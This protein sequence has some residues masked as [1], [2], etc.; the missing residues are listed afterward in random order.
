MDIDTSASVADSMRL[1]S[2]N[3]ASP[4]RNDFLICQSQLFRTHLTGNW[5]NYHIFLKAFVAFHLEILL[6]Y[7]MEFYS[8]IEQLILAWLYSV[9]YTQTH[10]HTR[11]CTHTC[12]C[13]QKCTHAHTQTYVCACIYVCMYTHKLLIYLPHEFSPVYN[14]KNIPARRMVSVQFIF[15]HNKLL[16]ILLV[17]HEINKFHSVK[18]F[19]I[20]Q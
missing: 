7:D 13:T 1:C 17:W 15:V 20:P 19:T 18:R 14:L 5:G 3:Q 6:I 12:Q 8:N 11:V 10:T 4:F 2:E 9:I 16:T